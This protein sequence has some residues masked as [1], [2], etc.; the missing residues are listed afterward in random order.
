MRT[1]FLA[2]L[3]ASV[4][5]GQA[6]AGTFTD[7]GA[8]GVQLTSLSVHGHIASG[9]IGGGSAWRWTADQGATLM[10][11]FVSSQGMN[12]YAQPIVGAY[13]PDNNAADA[14][15]A[16]YYSNTAIIG[17]PDVLG[18]Y[19]NTGGGTGQGISTAY[20][21]SDDGVVVGLAYDET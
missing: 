5:A 3:I 11:G 15:G 7:L 10:D 21:V 18:G 17:E 20:G 9:V 12:S 8:D 14:V 6:N 19:P 1:H 4:L 2:G 16:M 13:T